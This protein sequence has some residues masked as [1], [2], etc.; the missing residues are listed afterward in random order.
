VGAADGLRRAESAFQRALALN[1]ELALAHNLYANFEVDAGRAE[2]AMVRLLQRARHGGADADLFAGLVAACRYC[3]LLDVS[4]AAH[5]RATRLDPSVRTS[6]SYTYFMRGDYERAAAEERDPDGVMGVIAA[7]DSPLAAARY[8]EIE[9]SAP[10]P[11]WRQAATCGRCALEGRGKETLRAVQSVLGEGL[12]DPEA[13]YFF[14][15]FLAYVGEQG[16]ALRLI[17]ESVEGGFFCVEGFVRDPW[18]A[19]LRGSAGFARLLDQ[20]ASRQRQAVRS[21]IAAGRERMLGLVTAA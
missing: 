18:L 14:A 3:G 15:R 2:A 8:A 19:G 4:L 17:E 20:A 6:G 7:L 12:H 11:L 5:E 21:F 1:P 10:R 9:R 16:E 13:R